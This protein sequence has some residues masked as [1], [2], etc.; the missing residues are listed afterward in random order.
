MHCNGDSD[1][2]DKLFEQYFCTRL[3]NLHYEDYAKIFFQKTDIKSL[4]KLKKNMNIRQLSV[5]VANNR[6]DRSATVAFGHGDCR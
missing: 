4:T 1:G 3:H 5:K 2:D 6:F